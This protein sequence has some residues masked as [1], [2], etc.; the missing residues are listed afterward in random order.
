MP[1]QI[2]I[3]IV[4]GPTVVVIKADIGLPIYSDTVNVYNILLEIGG[5]GKFYLL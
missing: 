4:G 5:R 3:G 2:N 1:F